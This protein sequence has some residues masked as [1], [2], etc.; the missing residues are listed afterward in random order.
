MDGEWTLPEMERMLRKAFV[1]M[2]ELDTQLSQLKA[3]H[4]TL[5]ERVLGSDAEQEK[6]P[7]GPLD[8]MP[9]RRRHSVDED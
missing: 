9:A 8:E 4:H 3:S 5:T 1:R 2:E 7:Y 6:R